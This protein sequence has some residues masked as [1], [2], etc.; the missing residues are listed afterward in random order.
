[1]PTKHQ[2]ADETCYETDIVI[3]CG[4]IATKIF[5]YFK[6]GVTRR[7]CKYQ[8]LLFDALDLVNVESNVILILS[9]RELSNYST[10]TLV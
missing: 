1:M 3:T 7:M 10:F 4:S 8:N 5:M 6:Y 9:I 2:A